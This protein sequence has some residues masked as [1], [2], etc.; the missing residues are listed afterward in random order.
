M[1]TI[2][3]RAQPGDAH[4]ASRVA[5]AAKAHWGYSQ[6][7][8]DA[9]EPQLR[10]TSAYIAQHVVFVAEDEGLV[11]GV[12]AL[13]EYGTHR[14]LAHLWVHPMAQHSG[15]GSALLR[16]AMEESAGRDGPLRVESDPNAAGFYA[17]AGAVRVGDVPAA[18][19][20]EPSRTLP[21]FEFRSADA[22]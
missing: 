7:L 22:Q 8:L 6:A 1:N 2:I 14:D 10:F 4:E 17:R 9:W 13:E 20:G 3:R 19:P 15:L 21:L 18:V 11:V 16:R 5:R 12:C